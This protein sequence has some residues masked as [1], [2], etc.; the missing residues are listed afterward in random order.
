[1]VIT[2]DYMLA[3]KLDKGKIII[4]TDDRSVQFYLQGT[5]EE[6]GYNFYLKRMDLMKKTVKI[7]DKS[8]TVRG[9]TTYT[10]GRG[11]LAYIMNMF[12]D[13][14]SKETY[15]YLYRSLLSDSYV[16]TPFPNL[17]NYQNSDILH[18]LKYKVGLFQVAVGLGK[19]EMIATLTNYFRSIGKRVL[20]IC[21]GSKARDELDKRVN[22]RFGLTP[23][24]VIGD[25]LCS[26]ITSG[27]MNRKDLKKDV[28]LEKK[29]GSY[30]VVLVD[31]VEYTINPGGMFLYDRLQNAEYFYGF[32]GTADKYTGQA[33]TFREGL[34]ENI[35]RNKDLIKYFGPALVYRLPTNKQISQI[36]VKTKS[37]DFLK[38]DM[39]RTGGKTNIYNEVMNQI[40]TD[41]K[42]CRCI[43]K[44][45]K[46]Y[47]QTFIP[48]NN[49]TTV[50]TEWIEK[51]FKGV[52]R[53][54]LVCGEGY[55][56]YDLDGKMTNLNLTQACE[57][58]RE[59]LVDVI[60]STSAGYRALDF[61]GLENI[62][63]CIGKVAGVVIQALGRCSRGEHMN[64]IT[65]EPYGESR[66]IP[67]LSKAMEERETLFSEYYKYCMFD[68]TIIGEDTL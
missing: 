17:R 51:W 11:W 66:K 33:L 58:I 4:E 22:I 31:E 64:I 37:L 59:G 61:P 53:V 46:A 2:I 20:L 28:E 41:P 40:W 49:L 19:S 23:T 52:F 16:D 50:I 68:K 25:P 8:K 43:V 56:Y 7:Y 10:I 6:T 45:C 42:I 14:I 18:L 5:V 65:M 35:L 67:V 63:L 13:H 29:L 48:M 12:K 15:D 60:P 62:L 9:V 38:L 55:L 54:L 3:I 27:L 47:P 30:D 57:Y 21:P 1:M 44:I 36:V 34:S 39:P 32:S 26:I 24:S